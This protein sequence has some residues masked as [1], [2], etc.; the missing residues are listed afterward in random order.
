MTVTNDIPDPDRGDKDS[1]DNSE[2]P[3]PQIFINGD[4]EDDTE[5][6]GDHGYQMLQQNDEPDQDEESLSRE[7]ELAALVR[8][9]QADAENLSD[10]TR[11]MIE[12]S[13]ARQRAEELSEAAAV[14][15]SDNDT[16]NNSIELNDEKIETIKSLMS[17]VVL[18][19]VPSWAKDLNPKDPVLKDKVLNN[20]GSRNN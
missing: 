11:E 12:Q 20:H 7:E 2:D 3:P 16:R 17:G 10:S 15:S 9:A 5:D 4:S 14:W 6:I 18:G 13:T 1:I 8:A 19:N